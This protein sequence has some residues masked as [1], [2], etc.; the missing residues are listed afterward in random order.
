MSKNYYHFMSLRSFILLKFIEN[1]VKGSTFAVIYRIKLLSYC[2]NTRYKYLYVIINKITNAL[3][4]Q[5][6]HRM[7]F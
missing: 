2:S 3:F 6:Y 7:H 5:G 4:G 1:V